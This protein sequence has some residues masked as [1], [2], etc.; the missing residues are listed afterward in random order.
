MGSQPST[1]SSDSGKHP[2]HN[3]A[4]NQR[5]SFY[6]AALAAMPQ[7]STLLSLLL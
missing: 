7:D 5:M 1:K 4:G 2:S 6:T 3:H